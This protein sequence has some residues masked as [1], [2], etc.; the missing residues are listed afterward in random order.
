M[1]LYEMPLLLMSR[2]EILNYPSIG[3]RSLLAYK[4]TAKPRAATATPIG[5]KRPAVWIAW[6]APAEEVEGRAVVVAAA[7]LATTAWVVVCPLARVL[8]T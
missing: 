8:V 1:V 7:V 6:A 4:P 3:R 5:T 2:Y